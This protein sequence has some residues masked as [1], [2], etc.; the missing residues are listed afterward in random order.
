MIVRDGN[1]GRIG[2]V[3]QTFNEVNP[4]GEVAAELISNYLLTETVVDAETVVR[5]DPSTVIS[6]AIGEPLTLSL[7]I[8]A[9]KVIA[10]YQATVQFDATALRFVSGTNGDFL[11]AGAFF[12]EPKVEGNLIKLNAASLAGESNGDGTLA[13]L[14]FEVIAVKPSILTLSDV[15]LSNMVG[16]TFLPEVENTQIT[17]PT[18][19]AEDVN[20]DRQVNIADLVLVASNFGKTGQHATDVNGDGQVNIVDLVLVASALGTDAAAPARL[21]P[22]VLEMFT[23]ATVNLWLTEAKLTAKHTPRYQRGIRML[24]SLSAALISKETTLLAN[25]PNPFN[26][27]TWI[28]YHLADASAV[29]IR[30]YDARERVVR[31]LNLGHQQEGDYTSR[32]R[33]AYWDGRNDMGERVASGVYFYTLTAGDFTA[34]RK[35]LIRK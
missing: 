20:G 10:G 4:K 35:L 13:T 33:A 22:D 31:L 7:N 27:E 14:T 2:I 24:E 11:P 30:I 9:G 26:P 29:Q 6:P 32:N 8:K 17:Q 25:Y 1:R 16:E 19:F 34:T 23:A 28:P 18:R 5:I 3:Y 15:L 21:S 12:V